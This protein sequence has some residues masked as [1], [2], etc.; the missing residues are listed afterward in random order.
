MA[1]LKFDDGMEFETS[2][3]FR[4]EHRSDGWYVIGHGM[5]IPVKTEEDADEHI[6]ENK[7]RLLKYHN[8]KE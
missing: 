2:G 7:E 5:L 6:K 3:P 1:I 4:K 8:K